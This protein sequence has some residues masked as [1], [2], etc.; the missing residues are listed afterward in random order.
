MRVLIV[1][2]IWPPDVGGPASHGPGIA[3]FLAGRGHTVSA[4]VSAAGP[5]A[6]PGFAVRVTRRD[7]PLVLRMAAGMA[8]LARAVRQVDVVYATGIYHRTAAACR[9]AGT[10]LVVKLVN[11][12][13][14]ER[15]RNLGRTT[16]T[17]EAFQH[18]DGGDP[19]VRALRRARD[20][21]LDCAGEL[22]VPSEYLA[23]IARGW[24]LRPAVT[25]ISN[26]AVVTASAA[27]REQL[28]AEFEMRGVTAVF[29]GRLVRQKNLQLAI[30]A[31]R[32]VPGLNLAIVGDG[33]EAPALAQAVAAAGVGDR[34]RIHPPVSQQRAGDWMRAADV[35]LL[36][37]DW[38]NF[39]HA[40]VES[41]AQG[42]PVIATAVGGVPEI[43]EHGRTGWLVGA[44]DREALTA[45]LARFVGDDA[46]RLRLRSGAGAAG[47]RY[48][49]ERLFAL[50]ED[51]LL[52]TARRREP[53]AAVATG[54]S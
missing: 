24:G 20:R 11:D 37:S 1:S 36:P 29:A 23:R 32:D 33:P 6:E 34:V 18:D 15:A 12:P 46:L 8:A 52:R 31:L 47:D 21:A 50:A 16:S 2:G 10:P 45:A 3:R 4:V 14:Y 7:R 13:A 9:L 25:V 5:V 44:G 54:F 39:P 28:R 49:P 51:V 48:R 41:L 38:E 43:V 19:V 26:P 40:V 17:L 35:T 27:S 53:A 42:T 30:G 22:I